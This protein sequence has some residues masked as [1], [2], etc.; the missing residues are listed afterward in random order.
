MILSIGWNLIEPTTPQD[1][2][3]PGTYT[4]PYG[5]LET[6]NTYLPAHN[7]KLSLSILPVTTTI[8]SLP[9]N[10]QSA[11]LDD[12]LVVCRF[13]NMLTYVLSLIPNVELVSL[14]LGNELDAYAGALSVNFWSQ[15]LTLFTNGVQTVHQLRPGTKVTVTGT[16]YG[17]IG[18]N[19]LN[20]LAQGGLAQLWKSADIVNVTYY[21]IKS[22]FTVKSPSVVLSDIKNLVGLFPNKP[23]FFNEVGYPSGSQAGSS[24]D[25][26]MLFYQNVV[27][28]W[29]QYKVNI[30]HMLF[31]RLNDYSPTAAQSQANNYGLQSNS[32]FVSYLQTLGLRT[33]DGASKKAFT[34]IKSLN[35]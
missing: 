21:P 9:S 31:V 1:C 30:P 23:I 17:A 12:P 22:N 15:Y 29:N 5:A 33:Y 4:D 18:Q 20:P 24:E 10:L 8:N 34:Y 25:Q 19:S 7:L 3:T 14:Q 2:K 26:Q 35:K 32:A 28:V 6:F 13:V 11:A 16:L 27:Q